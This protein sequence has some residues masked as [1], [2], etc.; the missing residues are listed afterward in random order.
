MEKEKIIEQLRSGQHA[1]SLKEL[2][3]A[4]PSVSHFIQ[5]NGGNLDDARDMF[6]ES[7]LVF[8]RNVQ[9]KE[10]T[11]TCSLNTY[12]F[13]IAKYL[14]KD[15]L[16]KKNRNVSFEA[17]EHEFSADVQT[18]RQEEMRMKTIDKVLDQLGQKCTEILQLFY[19]KKR[20]MEEIAADLGYKNVDTVKTQKY[21]CLERAKLMANEMILS[22]LTEE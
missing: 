17:K 6:Q 7:L 5:V 1:A 2:Y 21:K 10:F 3:K 20:K 4:F 12:L 11:L 8:Y 14:W 18:Y 22:S 9:K 16:K 13:S 15:E 19:Y